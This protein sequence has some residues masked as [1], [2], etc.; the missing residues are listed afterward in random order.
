MQFIT[1]S[2][3]IKN[4]FENSTVKGLTFRD[5]IYEMRNFLEKSGIN[6]W[7]LQISL[8][9]KSTVTITIDLPDSHMY[10]CLTNK[11]IYYIK[12]LTC[13]ETCNFNYGGFTNEILDKQ[14][15]DFTEICSKIIEIK[16]YSIEPLQRAR[17]NVFLKSLSGSVISIDVY[18]NMLVIDLKRHIMK[19]EGIPVEQQRLICLG[20]NLV[21]DWVLSDKYKHCMVHI[22]LGLRGGMHHYSSGRSD[23]CSVKPPVTQ[24]EKNMLKVITFSIIKSIDIVDGLVCKQLTLYIHPDCPISMIGKIIGLEYCPEYLDNLTKQQISDIVKSNI[25][26]LLSKQTITRILDIVHNK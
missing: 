12:V 21:D 7:H 18:E 9:M 22:I 19:I 16:F 1:N 17:F 5:T 24:L 6:E 2:S 26:E 10:Y 14:L 15:T 13:D 25:L 11:N 20:K 8:K 4:I 3:I 23:Y